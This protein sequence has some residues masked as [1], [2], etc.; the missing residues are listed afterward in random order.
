MPRLLISLLT[1]SILHLFVASYC[2]AIDGSCG[3]SSGQNLT[4]APATGLC[5]TGTAT[6]VTGTGPWSWT[7][8]GSNGGT[9]ASCSA[10]ILS[11]GTCGNSN[12]LTFSAA[13]TANLCSTGTSTPLTGIGPW[14]WTCK[15]NGSDSYCL[16]YI[17]SPPT[18]SPTNTTWQSIGPFGGGVLSIAID[19]AN[20]QTIFAGTQSFIYRSTNG[21]ASW[22]ASSNGT[23]VNF[24]RKIVID[25]TDNKIVYAVNNNGVFKSIDG[26][27][28]W[29][30]KGNGILTYARTL[31]IDPTNNQ[32]LYVATILGT[33]GLY[34]SNNGGESWTAISIGFNSA[35]SAYS[36]AI[37]PTN[38]QVIFAVTSNQL[39]K[40]INGGSSWTPIFA[41]PTNLSLV[42]IDPRNSQIIYIGNNS[43]GGISKSVDSG[44]TWTKIIGITGSLTSLVFDLNNGLT[45]Y[46]G[47]NDLVLNG[48]VSK[49]GL[50]KS[51]DGGVNWDKIV[52]FS[53]LSIAIDPANSQTVYAGTNGTEGLI[54]SC[55]WGDS[56]APVIAGITNSSPNFSIID[57][58]DSQTIYAATASGGIYKSNNE[59][60]Q[61]FTINS[62][63]DL[64]GSYYSL[65]F[66]PGNHAIFA[67]SSRGIFKSTNDG[68]SWTAINTGLTDLS[69]KALAIDPTNSQTLYA[70][71]VNGG[72]FKSSNSGDSW[73]PI[74]TGLPNKVGSSDVQSIAID[75]KDSQTL[76]LVMRDYGIFKSIDGGGTWTPKTPGLLPELMLL[77]QLPSI[78]LIAR[79]YILGL[80]HREC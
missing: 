80:S 23:N 12:G 59:G 22:K 72:V 5:T 4:A 64:S 57:P 6:S 13:P 65:T 43:S 2:F 53:I 25:P 74:I 45:V 20:S 28:S 62:G 60:A 17:E 52:D 42:A 39:F 70:G 38:S 78:Q 27:D 47:T 31:A 69:V 14:A 29:S 8:Q 10:N 79:Y 32:I 46:A 24:F 75:P 41:V 50:F 19:P 26:G 36:F 71:G 44:D 76:Y 77:G 66:A 7:C 21:G 56:W 63:L 58:S 54:K 73:N 16:A 61:W 33:A 40:S 48:V 35:Y 51:I 37:D 9:T 34:K 3:S 18:T 15:G 1:L 30:Q 68:S 55:N 49:G 11:R 67:I